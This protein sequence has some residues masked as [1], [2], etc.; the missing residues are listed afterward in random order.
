MGGFT[1][2]RQNASILSAW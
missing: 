2:N 1:F